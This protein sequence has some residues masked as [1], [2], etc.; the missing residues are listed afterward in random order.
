MCLAGG[1]VQ[2]VR[3][4]ASTGLFLLK[5]PGPIAGGPAVTSLSL[6]VGASVSHAFSVLLPVVSLS[7]HTLSKNGM[8]SR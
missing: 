5:A 7:A 6:P 2:E 3:V 1:E 4:A 8:A